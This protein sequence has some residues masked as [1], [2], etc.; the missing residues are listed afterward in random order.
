MRITRFILCIGLLFSASSGAGENL[1]L[2][3]IPAWDGRFQPGRMTEIEVRVFSLSEGIVSLEVQDGKRR[4][5]LEFGV[6]AN[7]TRAIH[8]PLEPARDAP[9]RVLASMS[10]ET[11]AQAERNVLFS[12]SDSAILAMISRER[13][14]AEKSFV[15]GFP[16][17]NGLVKALVTDKTALPETAQGYAAIDALVLDYSVLGDLNREQMAALYHYLAQCGRLI[18]RN[19]PSTAMEKLRQNAGCE[20]GFLKQANAGPIADI[21]QTLLEREPPTLPSRSQMEEMMPDLTQDRVFLPVLALISGYFALLA[22][23]A[24]ASER[25]W[26]LFALPLFASALAILAWHDRIPASTLSLWMETSTGQGSARYSALFRSKGMGRWQR[27]LEMPLG[28]AFSASEMDTSMGLDAI[29]GKPVRAM[30]Q[31]DFFL[32]SSLEWDWQG[33]FALQAPLAVTEKDGLLTIFNISGQTLPAGWV[34]WHGAVYALPQL[35]PGEEWSPLREKGHHPG[36]NPLL[37]RL[38]GGR[39]AALI[40]FIPGDY[41]LPTEAVPSQGWLLIRAANENAPG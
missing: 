25:S 37:Q 28:A 21:L 23:S 6:E 18:M 11:M 12:A 3:A 17:R 1:R 9:V 38:D 41:P 7:V 16:T 34:G 36:Q 30:A 27:G 10:G 22:V 20:G 26:P 33:S 14:E 13:G 24:F 4:M 15:N 40:P 31:R 5:D 2:E 39:A 29:T 35:V 32:L 8:L 19:F